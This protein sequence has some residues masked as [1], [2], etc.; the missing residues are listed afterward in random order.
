MPASHLQKSNLPPSAW[1]FWHLCFLT[2]C[3]GIFPAESWAEALA[4]WLEPANS[5]W[6]LGEREER[7]RVSGQLLRQVAVRGRKEFSRCSLDVCRIP[8]EF[9]HLALCNYG[10]SPLRTPILRFLCVEPPEL[11]DSQVKKCR[12]AGEA[13]PGCAGKWSYSRQPLEPLTLSVCRLT[14]GSGAALLSMSSTASAT[15]KHRA[16]IEAREGIPFAA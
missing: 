6:T 3:C 12:E 14:G 7:E 10:P 5:P 2:P 16:A 8:Q 1:Q 15:H 9:R 11:R 4:A 13:L